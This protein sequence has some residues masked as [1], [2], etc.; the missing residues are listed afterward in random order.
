MLDGVAAVR[1]NLA[2]DFG[3]VGCDELGE[4]LRGHERPLVE[5]VV[6]AEDEAVVARIQQSEVVPDGGIH[7][8]RGFLMQAFGVFV[9]GD[10]QLLKSVSVRNREGSVAVRQNGEPVAGKL[11]QAL[12]GFDLVRFA[13]VLHADRVVLKTG[14]YLN[15]RFGVLGDFALDLLRGS[16]FQVLLGQKALAAELF[17]KLKFQFKRGNPIGNAQ[18]QRAEKSFLRRHVHPSCGISKSDVC[19]LKKR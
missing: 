13:Q 8:V 11:V 7:H 17:R 6:A 18:I 1:T 10:G 16:V 2:D 19:S 5:A 15:Q 9:H 14:V 4:H 12:R 3:E